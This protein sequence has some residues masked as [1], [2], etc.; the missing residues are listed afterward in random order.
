LM[1]FGVPRSIESQ[2]TN[3]ADKANGLARYIIQN[4]GI[5]IADNQTLELALVDRA[6]TIIV[7]DQQGLTLEDRET[8]INALEM[9]GFVID[10]SG[11]A[12]Y[13]LD[14]Y[15]NNAR[16]HSGSPA[17][18]EL[19]PNM[20]AEVVTGSEQKI[21]I[22][23]G[24]D[25][26]LLNEVARFI[27]GLQLSVVILHERPNKGR[28]IITKFREE[29]ADAVFAV[30]LM[31][32]DDHG[33][34]FGGETNP[35]ARQNVVFELGFFVGKLGPERV[36]ALTKDKVEYPSDYHGVLY[37]PFDEGGGWKYRLAQEMRAAG[38]KLEL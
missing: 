20:G 15:Q 1:E 6:V 3:L 35:R 32:P 26:A 16:T 29:S 17:S 8:L 22:V 11:S 30:V 4:P 14:A 24:H 36:V 9:D 18:R 10:S 33:G 2:A 21:F 25:H 27:N 31:T 5:R 19:V 34:E 13:D 7:S 37:V 28:T 38:I 12:R 23:H